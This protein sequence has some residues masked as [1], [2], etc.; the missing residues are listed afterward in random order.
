MRYQLLLSIT[1]LLALTV[2]SCKKDDDT[3]EV[4]APCTETR[5]VWLDGN[6]GNFTFIT[7]EPCGLQRIQAL[8]IGYAFQSQPGFSQ[9]PVVFYSNQEVGDS[10]SVVQIEVRWA[11]IVPDS[12]VET[13]IT[14]TDTTLQLPVNTI[15]NLMKLGRHYE[16]LSVAQTNNTNAFGMGYTDETGKVWEYVVDTSNNFTVTSLDGIISQSPFAGAHFPYCVC[17]F[18]YDVLLKEN[19]SNDTLRLQGTGRLGFR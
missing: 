2:S 7:S 11:T 13:I 8:D 5:P 9:H 4:T 14:A 3:G 15:C 12:L 18:S 16:L 1:M 17:T 6:V 19:L 10:T